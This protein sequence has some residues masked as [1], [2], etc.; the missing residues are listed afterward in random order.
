MA[1][2][3][4]GKHAKICYYNEWTNKSSG[5]TVAVNTLLIGKRKI[6]HE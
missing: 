1:E 3:T 6:Y 2:I 5:D 4:L